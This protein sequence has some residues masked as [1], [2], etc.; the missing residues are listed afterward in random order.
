MASSSEAFE[1]SLSSS[2]LPILAPEVVENILSHLP[3]RCLVK[4]LLVCQMWKDVA[5]RIMKRRQRMVGRLFEAIHE[6]G[7][8]KGDTINTLCCE[9]C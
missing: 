5:E 3:A 7:S 2:C 9:V 6:K 1:R 8:C 4:V